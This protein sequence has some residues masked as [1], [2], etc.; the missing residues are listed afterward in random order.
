MEKERYQRTIELLQRIFRLLLTP[1][2]KT[3][4]ISLSEIADLIDEDDWSREE[5]APCL[6]RPASAPGE[7][8]PGVAALGV[9]ARGYRPFG[10]CPLPFAAGG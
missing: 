1:L 5:M 9:Y 4:R 3:D 2:V 6:Y 8:D 10:V 7:K